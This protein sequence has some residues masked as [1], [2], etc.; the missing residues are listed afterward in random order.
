MSTS[1]IDTNNLEKLNSKFMSNPTN[2]LIQNT[3]CQNT[4]YSV[5]EN[6]EY[7]QQRDIN[8]SNEVDPELDVTNQGGTG[9]CWMFAPL[10]VMRSEIIRKLKLDREFE[11]SQSYLCFYEKLEKCNYFLCQFME[12]DQINLQDSSIREILAYGCDDGAHWETFQNLV[13]K[14]G[15]IPRSCYKESIN[16]FMT[17][18]LIEVLNSKLGEF[19]LTL[20]SEKNKSKRSKMKQEMINQIHDILCKML[21]TPPHPTQKFYWSFEFHLDTLD[22]VE[23]EQ[24]RRK[25][26]KFENY[27]TKGTMHIT[28][29]EFYDKFALTKSEDLVRLAHDPRNPY[30]KYYESFRNDFVIGGK[31]PGYFNVPIEVLSDACSKSI[32]DNTPVEFDCDVVKFLNPTE[33]LLDDNAYDFDLTLGTK[34]NK[35]SK[36]DMMKCLRTGPTHAMTMVGVDLCNG[37]PKKWKIENSWGADGGKNVITGHEATGHYHMSHTWFEKYVFGAVVRY[38]YVPKQLLT[39]YK[40]G[41]KSPITLPQFDLMREPRKVIP[42]LGNILRK[43]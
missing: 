11:L 18:V 29:L 13:E 21:G 22:H 31:K 34:I 43:K 15:V 4:L 1:A 30:Y 9:R 20:I 12:M 28:P 2:L 42:N 27:Q 36:V 7:M 19:A 39:R 10:N 26:E 17:S 40:K 8:F 37:I 3:L 16:S 41:Q 32:L 33:E 5:S 24:K 38:N 23:R 25:T 14:Y 35:L 6:R